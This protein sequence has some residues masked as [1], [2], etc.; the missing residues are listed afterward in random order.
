MTNYNIKN[1]KPEI[2]MTDRPL[3]IK[4]AF[5][6]RVKLMIFSYDFTSHPCHIAVALNVAHLKSIEQQK[7]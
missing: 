2:L 4:S 5:I 3:N 6:F 7:V 1:K